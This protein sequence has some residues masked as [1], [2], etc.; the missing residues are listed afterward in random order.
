[1]SAEV[2]LVDGSR[3]RWSIDDMTEPRLLAF[4]PPGP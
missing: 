2:V 3:L 4:A 1:M